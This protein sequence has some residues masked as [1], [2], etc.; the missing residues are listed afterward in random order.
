[1]KIFL[2]CVVVAAA[3]VWWV[4]H[5][6]HE[7]LVT[8]QSGVVALV[9][10]SDSGPGEVLSGRLVVGTTGCLSVETGTAVELVVWPFDS[11]L[12]YDGQGITNSRLALRPVQDPPRADAR[13]VRVGESFRAT[14]R[15]LSAV[16]ARRELPDLPDRC[17]TQDPVVVLDT[18]ESVVEP[19]P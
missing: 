1:M 7:P 17:R 4:G 13:L 12:S 8:E 16:A 10:S 15:T 19:P 2:A 9:R 18:V 6:R 14:G 11:N 3:W 5:A